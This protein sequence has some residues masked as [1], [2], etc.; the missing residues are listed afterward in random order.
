M[1]KLVKIFW[2]KLVAEDPGNFGFGIS[3]G[4]RKSGRG[5][6]TNGFFLVCTV[7]GGGG[8]GVGSGSS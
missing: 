1:A 5:Y 6:F 8:W 4:Q 7:P 3:A 2:A